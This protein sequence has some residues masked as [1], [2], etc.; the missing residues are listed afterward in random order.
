MQDINSVVLVGHLTKDMSL[1]YLQSG[2]A[3]GQFYLAVNRRRK[4]GDQWV[5]EASY[6]EVAFYGKLAETLRQFMTKGRFVAVCGMLKQD[7]WEKDGQRFSKVR[8]I[9]SNVELLGGKSDGATQQAPMPYQP[10][11]DAYEDSG[12]FADDGFDVGFPEEIP[13]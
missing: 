4:D 5:D 9:A 6:F 11:R 12:R 2:T 3:C 7:R 10:Q 13:F 8:V 1:S